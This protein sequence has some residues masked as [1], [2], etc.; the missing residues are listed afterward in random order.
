M[1]FTL[2]F[3]L[4]STPHQNECFSTMRGHMQCIL[5][6]H[7]TL[8]ARERM[9]SPFACVCAQFMCVHIDEMQ[10]KNVMTIHTHTRT[11]TACSLAHSLR[12][13][14]ASIVPF[15]VAANGQQMAAHTFIVFSAA[16]N[17]SQAKPL[18]YFRQSRMDSRRLCVCV[19]DA[20]RGVALWRW[21]R[22][23]RCVW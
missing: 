12:E 14:F 9:L 16:P 6:K 10:P 23:R 21:G 7:T 18:S 17:S 15:L 22:R 5:I 8:A 13:S 20:K 4:Q 1:L 2:S 3:K 11:K 19:S